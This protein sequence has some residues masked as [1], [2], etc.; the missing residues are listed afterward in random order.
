MGKG[1]CSVSGK[2]AYVLMVIGAL[3]W[4]LVG[5][6]YFAGGNWNLVTMLLGTWPAV[7]A[8]VYIL[9]GLAGVMGLVMCC[10]SCDKK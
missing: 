9:V 6:G 2:I 5:A 3:N 8:V 1:S 4:G 7:E 10:S